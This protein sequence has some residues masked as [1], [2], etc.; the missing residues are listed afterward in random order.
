MSIGSKIGA[1]FTVA[2]VIIAAIG[3]SA[4]VSTQ[5]LLEANRWVTHTHEVIEGLEHALSVLKDAETGQ[6]GF[7]LTGEEPYLE[8]YNAA[9]GRIQHDIDAL[10]ALT[11]DNPAQQESLR[12]VKELS[13]AKLLELRETI[14]LRRQS[15]LEAALEVVRSDRGKTIMDKLRSVVATMTNR[16]QQLLE[17]RSDAANTSANRTIWTIALWMP[18]ALLALAVA[19]VV[20][21]RT[22]RFGGAAALPSTPRKQWGG[23]AVQYASAAIIV[24]VAVVLRWRLVDSFGPLPVFITLYPA[25]LLA[26]SIGGGGPGILATVLLALAA[27]YWFFPPYGSFYVAAPNDV[28]ALAIFIGSGL[29]LSILAE[30]LRRSRWAEAVSITREQQLEELSRLNEELSQQAERGTL[31][32]VGRAVAAI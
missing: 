6:R 5:R 23:I 29:F 20:R 14:Q 27:D 4:Y 13:D 7:V 21:M 3:A 31:A 12:Q 1:G 19:V 32:A 25:V 26:A 18:I 28:L 30:R 15:G 24:A 17:E 22:V 16:E 10:V 8:P 2:L 9:T 11:R